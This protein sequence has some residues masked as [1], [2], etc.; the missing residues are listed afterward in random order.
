MMR[1]RAQRGGHC[2]Q[3]PASSS[4][5]NC[6]W[7]GLR[8]HTEAECFKKKGGMPRTAGQNAAGKGRQAS[9]VQNGGAAGSDGSVQASLFVSFTLSRVT[10]VND[11]EAISG[12]NEAALLAQSA[13]PVFNSVQ[14]Y[15]I[16]WLGDLNGV[17]PWGKTENATK[18][19]FI[20]QLTPPPPPNSTVRY[21]GHFGVLYSKQNDSIEVQQPQSTRDF[22]DA[23]ALKVKKQFK[24]HVSQPSTP[25]SDCLMMTD[26]ETEGRRADK[27]AA[28]SSAGGMVH[29]PRQR[30][31]T[32]EEIKHA[33]FLEGSAAASAPSSPSSSSAAQNAAPS[34]PSSA[35]ASNYN[36]A[37]APASP[38]SSSA[39][40][41]SNDE[42]RLIIIDS[43]MQLIYD[44]RVR[45][46][47]VKA[48]GQSTPDTDSWMT[49]EQLPQE[50]VEAY[51]Q[52]ERQK[53]EAA[54]ARKDYDSINHS[55]CG[56]TGGVLLKDRSGLSYAG[57]KECMMTLTGEP[58]ARI[59][60]LFR[61]DLAEQIETHL[62]GRQHLVSSALNRLENRINSEQNG[63][64]RRFA[65]VMSRG[66]P[67]KSLE[68]EELP[69]HICIFACT[70]QPL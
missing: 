61:E 49:A 33:G 21:M 62:S 55:Q 19:A 13:L 63:H 40:S 67:K 54:I 8:G 5:S 28:Q 3:K 56:N 31:F 70:L 36:A 60:Q 32:E 2:P 66:L 43:K 11:A 18:S 44:Q 7:C 38:A 48:K 68:I 20:L 22:A 52:A 50:L 1:K 45:T 25:S 69:A 58:L 41:N 51:T 16:T 39:A 59:Q 65:F 64:S 30:S 29:V 10:K 27:A 46:Y 9:F 4:N 23:V 12:S 15:C 35:A 47:L 42:Q 53:K 17:I 14:L 34:S 57:C 26:E 37:S 24:G 6:G